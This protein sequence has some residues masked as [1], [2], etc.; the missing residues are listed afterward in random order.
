MME[1]RA[2]FLKLFEYEVQNRLMAYNGNLGMVKRKL[3]PEVL[4]WYQSYLAFETLN[5]ERYTPVAEKFGISTAP[6]FK[7]K[8]EVF[9][10]ALVL[11]ILSEL[12]VLRY[13]CKETEAY[14]AD[15]ERLR[16]IA[17]EED[18]EFFDYVVAQEVMQVETLKLRLEGNPQKATEVIDKFV[19]QYRS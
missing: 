17:P 7:T 15:L 9:V 16:D 1:H 3:E 13:M 10:G 18:R 14:V 12:S 5:Q 4:R 19:A 6:N 8:M 2:E 11:R